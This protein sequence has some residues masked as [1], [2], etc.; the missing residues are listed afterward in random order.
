LHRPPAAKIFAH[1]AAIGSISKIFTDVQKLDAAFA[2]G[3]ISA[4]TGWP[5]GM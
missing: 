5:G 3:V 2:E 1:S 4:A